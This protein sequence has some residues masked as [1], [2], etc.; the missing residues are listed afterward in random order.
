MLEKRRIDEPEFL[1]GLGQL[2][3]DFGFMENAIEMV[4]AVLAKDQE[5]GKAFI[6]PGNTFSQN[7]DLLR[8]IC[9]YRIK[10]ENALDGWMDAINDLKSL[11]DERN[12]IFHGML[13]ERYGR[14]QLVR[15]KKSKGK[16][17]DRMVVVEIEDGLISSLH[18]KLSN[19][20]RQLMDFW[21]DYYSHDE[22]YPPAAPSQNAY[23]SLSFGKFCHERVRDVGR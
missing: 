19:R 7:I 15:G 3:I 23:P 5:L 16:Q 11:F 13:D 12:R 8:R 9:N 20:R 4:I 2:V 6:P 1:Q 18:K 14:I 21:D 22:D 10:S 17:K